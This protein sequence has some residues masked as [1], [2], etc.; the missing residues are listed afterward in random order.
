MSMRS[1]DDQV[2]A[3]NKGLPLEDRIKASLPD[4]VDSIR[5]AMREAIK[6]GSVGAIGEAVLRAL[7]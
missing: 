6:D 3:E 5:L 7:G 1:F 2:W 4:E